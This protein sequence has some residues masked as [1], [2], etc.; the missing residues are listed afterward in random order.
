MHGSFGMDFLVVTG[1]SVSYLYS[2]VQIGMECRTGEPTVHVFFEAVGML[3]MFVT[4]GK[5]IEAYA[6]GASA[7][8]IR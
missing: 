5:F 8:A 6:K 1:T 2:M 3:L 7:G 4:V